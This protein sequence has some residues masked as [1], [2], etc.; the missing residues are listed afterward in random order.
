MGIVIGVVVHDSRR[1]L[2]EEAAGGLAG[3][4]LEWIGYRREGE[5]RERVAATLDRTR[6]DG[7][8]LGPVPYEACRDLLPADLALAITR[9][10]A[11]DLALAFARAR[12]AGR[13]PVPVSVDT[14]GPDVVD[15]V[16]GALGLDT[17]RIAGLPYAP[18]QTGDDVVAFHRA[19]LARQG[20]YVISARTVV[21]ERLADR[22]LVLN[23]A[24]VLSAVRA[25]LHGL[26][27]RV[28]SERA[29]ALRFAAGIFLPVAPDE[30]AHPADKV[31]VALMHLLMETPEFADAWIEDRDRRGV[32]VLAHKALFERV[33]R[34]WVTVPA[35]AHAEEALGIRVAAGFGVG[36]SARNGVLLAERA[37]ARSVAA[38]GGCGFLVEDSGVVIGPMGGTGHALTFLYREHGA[39]LDGLARTAGLSP[40]TLSRLVA[41]ERSLAGRPVSPGELATALGITNPSGRRLMRKLVAADLVAA[42]GSAQAHVRGRPTRLYR[43]ALGPALDGGA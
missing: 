29:T 31:R 33:T 16:A 22:A 38:G 18:E 41:L 20:G 2:F 34:G 42:A 12:S 6:L 8:L 14:F 25:D 21:G 3:V 13:E 27:M 43:L 37:L 17:R 4:T 35:L 9:R 24:P 19:A 32:L 36:G 39:A 30:Q 23:E 15:E 28:E 26:A 5:V 11:L 10:S 7:L 1:A 40:A